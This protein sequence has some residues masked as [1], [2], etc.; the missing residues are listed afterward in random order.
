M[1]TYLALTPEALGV[2]KVRGVPL[3]HMAYAV[4]GRG[5]LTRSA[6][7]SG[8]LMGLSDRCQTAFP[9]RSALIRQIVRECA[10]RGFGGVLADFDAASPP[11]RRPFL[12]TLGVT[13]EREGRRLYVPESLDVPHAKVLIGTAVSG[14]SLREYLRAAVRRRGAEHLALDVQRLRMDFTL[15]SFSPEGRPLSAE[16]FEKIRL[17]S[18]ASVFFSEPLGARYFTYRAGTET[19]FVL[20]D[21]AETLKAK[22]RLARSLGIEDAFFMFPEVKD[23]LHDLFP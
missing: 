22:L 6:K 2:S 7:P 13:L 5:K 8:G 11:D 21:D 20:F 3:V 15:P 4:S 12:D 16:D 1:A 9:D 23:L 17:Q 10:A 18:G 14:G 19:H